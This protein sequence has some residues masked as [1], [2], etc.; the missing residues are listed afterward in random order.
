M[1]YDPI[2]AHEYYEKHKKLKGRGKGRKSPSHSTKGFTQG[3]KASWQTAQSQLKEAKKV[4]GKSITTESKEKRAQMI[5]QV[6]LRIKTIRKQLMAMSKERRDATRASLK[7]L[8]QSIRA[9]LKTDRAELT[10]ETRAK[11]TQTAEDFERQKDEAYKRIK[12]GKVE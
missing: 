7:N 12:S 3:Q 10:A 4:A 9:N 5:E 6:N 8:I 2:K 11:H 1:A